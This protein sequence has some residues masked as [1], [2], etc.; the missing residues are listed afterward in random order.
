MAGRLDVFGEILEIVDHRQLAAI[1]S[2]EPAKPRKTRIAR[3]SRT[4]SSSSRRP[5]RDPIL[6]FGTV[7]I[8][9]TIKRHGVRRPFRSPGTTGSRN[10]GASVVSVVNTQIVSE[11]VAS[12][13]SSCTITAGRGFP[14]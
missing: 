12:K 8:L 3:L 7:V 4:R 2:L 5:T 14:A 13:R 9:S 11:A 6:V 1:H 10:N